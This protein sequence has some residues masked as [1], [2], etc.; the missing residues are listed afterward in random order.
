[1]S[2]LASVPDIFFPHPVLWQCSYFSLIMA[3][4]FGNLQPNSNLLFVLL[5]QV[6]K[7]HKIVRRVWTFSSV[8]PLFCLTVVTL[9]LWVLRPLNQ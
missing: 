5:I 6:Y 4:L 7:E 8:E 1:M 3:F 2:L 9:I